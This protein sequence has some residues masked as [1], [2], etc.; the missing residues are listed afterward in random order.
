MA[1]T[2]KT[3]VPKGSFLDAFGGEGL[4]HISPE[5]LQIPRLKVLQALSPELDEA[6][7]VYNDAAKN[8]DFYLTLPGVSLKKS[9]EVIP[10]HQAT[11]WIEYLPGRGG[12]VGRHLPGTIAVDKT[13]YAN[14]FNPANGNQIVE[15]RD[16]VVLVVGHEE[17]GPVIMSFTSSQIK[18]S[19]S[20]LSLV[21]MERTPGGK[22]AP[23]FAN[24]WNLT[25]VGQSNDK[26]SYYVISSAP[27]KVRMITE[28]E[29]K[30]L[31]EP[32]RSAANTL[33][34]QGI[35]APQTPV[36]IEHTGPVEEAEY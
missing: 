12:Y 23:I 25:S 33:Q 34:T 27:K 16:W 14:W 5:D 26:G 18:A 30:E 9:V 13:D 28:K 36:A 10:L 19:K 1:E 17:V 22:V 20:W 32:A 3:S 2:K 11:F 7:P 31:V 15:S 21:S 35:S 24:V 4:E 8:G 29:Y 6:K